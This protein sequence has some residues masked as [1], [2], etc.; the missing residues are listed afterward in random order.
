MDDTAHV[1]VDMTELNRAAGEV[2]ARACGAEQGLVTSG[3]FGST[4]TD[5]SRVYD[6]AK[7][8]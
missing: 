2:V 6:R 5:G 1:F 3:L 7:R 8:R 4:S